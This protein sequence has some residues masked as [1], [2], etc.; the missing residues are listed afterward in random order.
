MYILKRKP[1][2]CKYSCIQ[3]YQKL[4]FLSHFYNYARCN[5][6]D[7]PL[8]LSN[9]AGWQVPPIAAEHHQLPLK[10]TSKHLAGS[11]SKPDLNVPRELTIVW[12][13]RQHILPNIFPQT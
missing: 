7:D 10:T 1:K 12:M 2:V 4:F 5:R 3:S 11:G 6:F 9:P 8:S 13:E